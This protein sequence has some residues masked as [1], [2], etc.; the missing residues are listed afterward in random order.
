MTDRLPTREKIIKIMEDRHSLQCVAPQKKEVV[1][2]SINL[3][4]EIPYNPI[5]GCIYSLLSDENLMHG[6][7]L[8]F[9]D[10]KQ[11][12]KAVPFTNNYSEVNSELAYQSFQK[13]IKHFVSAVQ[14]P[15]LF[16]IDGTAID[17]ACH[18]SQTPVMFTLGIFK[19]LLCN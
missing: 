6:V 3:L 7:N 5:L 2:P 11:P 17:R 14:V 12:F 15:L 13:R 8:I 19:Q 9:P 4:I 10:P 16:F 18:H 1:L